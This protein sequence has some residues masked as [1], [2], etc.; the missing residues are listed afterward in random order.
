MRAPVKLTVRTISDT[1]HDWMKEGRNYTPLY[2]Q[3]EIALRVMI[4]RK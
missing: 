3:E 2:H 4:A 1:G